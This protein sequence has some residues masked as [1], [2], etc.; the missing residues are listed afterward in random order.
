MSPDVQF[1]SFIHVPV[2]AG[3]TC[4]AL[5][6]NAKDV[7]SCV[8]FRRKLLFHWCLFIQ[9]SWIVVAMFFPVLV[10]LVEY[11]YSPLCLIGF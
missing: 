4:S 3:P 10:V 7:S 6:V 2:S 1:G 5:P 11:S 9:V 8:R